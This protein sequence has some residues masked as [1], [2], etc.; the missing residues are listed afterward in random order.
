MWYV[1]VNDKVIPTPYQYYS[2]ALDEAI[3]LK[4]TMC[5][6]CT[7]VINEDQLDDYR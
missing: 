3:R 2:D 5:A 6:V 4:E 1:V 7:S